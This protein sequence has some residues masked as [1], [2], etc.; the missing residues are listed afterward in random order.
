MAL[1]VQYN[2]TVLNDFRKALEVRRRMLPTLKRKESALRAE[3]SRARKAI[4]SIAETY[5]QRIELLAPYHQLWTEF[6]QGLVEIAKIEIGEQK[7]AGI[8]I[9]V[10]KSVQLQ[11]AT[12]HVFYQPI[13]LLDGLEVMKDLLRLQLEKEIYTQQMHILEKSRKKTTQKVNLY[14]KVQIP[15]YESAIRKIKRFM[16]NEENV[17]KSAYKIV[18]KRK[19]GEPF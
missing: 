10:L 17:A 9:P 19:N 18:K 3:I 1:E 16:E 12:D 2:K 15:E 7:V 8:P 13:W 11:L 14:E 4:K 5:R 6:D